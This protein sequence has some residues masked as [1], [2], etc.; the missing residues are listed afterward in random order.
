[1]IKLKLYKPFIQELNNLYFINSSFLQCRDKNSQT[2]KYEIKLHGRPPQ[3]GLLLAELLYPKN[4]HDKL[5]DIGTGT[6]VIA[7][8]ASFNGYKSIIAIDISKIECSLSLRNIQKNKDTTSIHIINSDTALAIY[9]RIDVIAAN[10]PQLPAINVKK[11]YRNFAGITGYEVIDKVILQAKNCLKI[12][13]EI[14]LYVLGFLGI[15][16]GT[17]NIPSLFDRLYKNGFNPTY[18]KKF[19]RLLSPTSKIHEAISVIKKRY[20]NSSLV[21]KYP[22]VKSYE[23]YLVKAKLVDKV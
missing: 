12:N 5:L 15:N 8:G 20:P 14:C 4:E 13:G 16:E 6:G 1:M 11:D 21:K 9:N 17:K 7:I 10:L 18:L 2:I 23:V 19:D 3:G 22:N